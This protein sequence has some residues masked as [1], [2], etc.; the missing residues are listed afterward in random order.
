MVGKMIGL[1]GT[2]DMGTQEHVSGNHV[3]KKEVV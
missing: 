2:M 1:K 3:S